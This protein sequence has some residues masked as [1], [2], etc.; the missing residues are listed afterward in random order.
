MLLAIGLSADAMAV[1]AA[2]GLSA[3]GVR[4]ENAVSV[5]ALFGGFQAAMPVAGGI[6]GS[7]FG[8]G[9]AAWNH[10][11]AF[12]LLSGIGIKMLYESWRGEDSERSSDSNPFGFRV[13]VALA[14]ATSI[15]ALAAGITLSVLGVR[16]APAVATI[17]LTTAVLSF[18]GVYAGRK[19]GA[20]LG[21]RVEVLGGMVL[22]GLGVKL[23]VEHL[24]HS[25][26]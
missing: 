25:M 19:F 22:I 20:T 16:L 26:G 11:V 21:K 6:L 18:A 14:I 24:G 23:L 3:K 15:D 2:R 7:R 4:I 17:G 13:L 10:W 12:V 8:A 9:F 5:A 1:A